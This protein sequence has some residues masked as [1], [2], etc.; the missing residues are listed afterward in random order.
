MQLSAWLILIVKAS[1]QKNLKRIHSPSRRLM[2]VIRWKAST[3]VVRQALVEYLDTQQQRLHVGLV[4]PRTFESAIAFFWCDD[5]GAVCGV[6]VSAAE[7]CPPAHLIPAVLSL[8]LIMSA[9]EAGDK[10][11]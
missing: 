9:P 1:L 2:Q 5:P 10:Y 4:S 8:A 11:V 7:A 6:K 3:V